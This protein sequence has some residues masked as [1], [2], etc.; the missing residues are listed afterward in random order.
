VGENEQQ[1]SP[2]DNVIFE[3]GYFMSA[4]GK[5]RTIIIVQEGAKVLADY[6]GH[7][8]IPLQN[9]ND[10]SSIKGALNKAFGAA[11]DPNTATHF[12]PR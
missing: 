10:I 2:R 12:N 8:F 9:P 3:A 1:R 6:S 11:P 7:I 4:H 5:D